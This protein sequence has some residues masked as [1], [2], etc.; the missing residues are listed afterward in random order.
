MSSDLRRR[1]AQ[2]QDDMRVAKDARHRRPSATDETC[3]AVTDRPSRS[4]G[5]PAAPARLTR[6]GTLEDPA[7]A[8]PG[9]A[10]EEKNFDFELA[11]DRSRLLRRIL[12][13]LCQCCLNCLPGRLGL[14]KLIFRPPPWTIVH[15]KS[16][17][18]ACLELSARMRD[19]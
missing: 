13:R 1:G 8:A 18:S 9:I 16:L 19:K 14:R 17:R 10:R 3:A 6:R 4:R 2:R 15:A 7:G 12:F 5:H 11:S